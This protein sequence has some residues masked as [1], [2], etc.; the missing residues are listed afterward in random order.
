MLAGIS[1]MTMSDLVAEEE[2]KGGKKSSVQS[3]TTETASKTGSTA[4]EV[5]KE[6]TASQRTKLMDILNKGDEAAL[7][8]LPGVGPARAKAIVKARPLQDLEALLAVDGMGEATVA[9][10]VTHA[11]AGFPVKEKKEAGAAKGKGQAESKAK[12]KTKA[13]AKAKGEG[14][15]EAKP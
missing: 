3:K 9:D 5:G 12:A 10:L 1:L 2:K 15:G 7:T 6:L 14:K 4:K 11:K 13:K 8:S